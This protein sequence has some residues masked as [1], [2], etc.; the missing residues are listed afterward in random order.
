[1]VSLDAYISSGEEAGGGRIAWLSDAFWAVGGIYAEATKLNLPLIWE[2][3]MGI[4]DRLK[5]L[6][7]TK[8]MSRV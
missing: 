1:L 6:R 2:T 7:E 3:M 4:G 5:K 8:D